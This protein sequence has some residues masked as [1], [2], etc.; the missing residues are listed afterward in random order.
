M[1]KAGTRKKR[2]SGK[3]SE[4]V[5][6]QIQSICPSCGSTDKTICAN[7]NNPWHSV[8]LVNPTG[9]KLTEALA[10]SLEQ[11]DSFGGGKSTKLN[12]VRYDLVPH[13]F[14]QRTAAR[15]A[16]GCEKYEE[17]NFRN[18]N[19]SFV[20]SRINHFYNHLH[21]FLSGRDSGFLP[22]DDDNLAAVSWCISFFMELQETAAGREKLLQALK[23]MNPRLK[24]QLDNASNS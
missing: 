11:I 12:N 19:E 1:A 3:M 2:T 13:I 15:Y 10:D 21:L 24:E 4:R 17:Y 23:T 20:R 16:K 8:K 22:T 5:A 7:C 9:E 14:I 18:G 6:R